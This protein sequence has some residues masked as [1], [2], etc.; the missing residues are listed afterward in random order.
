MQILLVRELGVGRLDMYPAVVGQGSPE[1]IVVNLFGELAHHPVVE[2]EITAW[3]TTAG[4]TLW[5]RTQPCSPFGAYSVWIGGG[6]GGPGQSVVYPFR[7]LVQHLVVE[8]TRAT[9]KRAPVE[10]GRWLIQLCS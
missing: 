2:L 7:G 3:G 9:S 6:D 10:R 8:L 4:R 5:L 1:L